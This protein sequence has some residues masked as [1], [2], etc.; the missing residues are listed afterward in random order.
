MANS[1]KQAPKR[2]H[3][4]TVLTTLETGSQE[5]DDSSDDDMTNFA[6]SS[7]IKYIAREKEAATRK[8]MR[9]EMVD[10][11]AEDL[12]F[13]PT[14]AGYNANRDVLTEAQEAALEE[15]N[16]HGQRLWRI[17]NEYTVEYSQSTWREFAAPAMDCGAV[18]RSSRKTGSF[19]YK[20]QIKLIN[21]SRDIL[22]LEIHPERH[23]ENGMELI[24]VSNTIAPGMR[25]HVEIHLKPNAYE[26]GEHFGEFFVQLANRRHPER[27]LTLTIPMYFCVISSDSNAA[28]KLLASGADTINDKGVSGTAS[29]ALDLSSKK[30]GA[31]LVM[32]PRKV[33]PLDTK[34]DEPTEQVDGSDSDSDSDSDVPEHVIRPSLPWR[35]RSSASMVERYKAVLPNHFRP[36]HHRPPMPLTYRNGIH[37]YDDGLKDDA[38]QASTQPFGVSALGTPRTIR[39]LHTTRPARLGTPAVKPGFKSFSLR[40]RVRERVEPA[41]FSD[42]QA[43]EGKESAGSKPASNASVIPR[44]NSYKHLAPTTPSPISARTPKFAEARDTSEEQTV[45]DSELSSPGG[46]TDEETLAELNRAEQ[47]ELEDDSSGDEMY[48]RPRELYPRTRLETDSLIQ[49]NNVGRLRR[50]VRGELPQNAA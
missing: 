34:S 26:L 42:A 5:N 10:H 36:G 35:R 24:I 12:G 15:C 38:A 16:A 21:L 46:G 48:E 18:F 13:A 6:S 40:P 28:K 45:G 30:P 2:Q 27:N 39:V 20:Y 17:F 4:H 31:S 47:I 50:H 29:R 41:R 19:T 25:S 37:M 32:N 49:V 43:A 3:L 7:Q 23:L 8:D 9:G 33:P 22:E 1:L 11:E 14:P 44:I